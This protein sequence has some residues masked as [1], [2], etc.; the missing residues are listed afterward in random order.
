ML[1]AQGPVGGCGEFG[2]GQAVEVAE[3][4][5]GGLGA[6]G[7]DDA[8]EQ[9]E[10]A[11][12]VLEADDAG[13]PGQGGDGGGGEDGVVAL[14]DD[15]RERGGGGELGVVRQQP[16]LAGDDEIGRQG[17]QPVGARG[18]REPGEL[19]GE[20]GA[21]ARAGDHRDPARGLLDRGRDA[22]RELPGGERVELAGAAAGE[23]GGRAR[24]DAVAYMGAEGGRVRGAVRS[25]RGHGE[26]QGAVQAVGE[27]ALLPPGGGGGRG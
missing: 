13:G 7:A 25:V 3:V 26:E 24:V 22:V 5:V 17:E 4:L 2:G 8:L 9:I 20:R 18:V 15:D 6:D 10:V 11:H 16:L 14:V 19:C 21:V 27:P 1:D 23:D 12:P